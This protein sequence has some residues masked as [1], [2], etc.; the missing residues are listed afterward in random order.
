MSVATYLKSEPCKGYL[1]EVGKQDLSAQ[2]ELGKRSCLS[3]CQESKPV[4]WLRGKENGRLL[5]RCPE[6]NLG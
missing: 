5:L 6:P 2:A 3:H 1:E 4:G